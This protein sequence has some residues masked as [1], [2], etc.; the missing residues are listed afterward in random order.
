MRKYLVILLLFCMMM[1]MVSCGLSRRNDWETRPDKNNGVSEEVPPNISI[2]PND[3]SSISLKTWT[4]HS[5]DKINANSVPGNNAGKEYKVYMARGETEGFQIALRSDEDISGLSLKLV[6][7]TSG[8]SYK[9]YIFDTLYSVGDSMYPDPARNYTEGENFDLNAESTLSL[10]VEFTSVDKTSSGLYKYIFELR[11]SEDKTV[12]QYEITVKVWNILMPSKPT[13]AT[14]VGIDKDSIL[15]YYGKD[16]EKMSAET[17]LKYYNAM[18]SEGIS[19]A[20]LPYDILDE[21]ANEYMSDPRVTSFRVP[22]DVSDDTLL[23]YY[24]KIKVNPQWLRKAYFMPMTEPSTIEEINRFV[25]LA[26]RLIRL[27]PLIKV[28]APFDTDIEIEEGRD[29][30]YDM[31]YYS[32][33]WCPKLCMWDEDYSYAGHSYTHTYSFEQRMRNMM[34]SGYGVWTYMD[35]TPGQPYTSLSLTGSGLGQRASFWQQYQ[36]GINGF[37]YESST[38]WRGD[39]WESLDNGRTDGNGNTVY[40]EGILIYP[41]KNEQG[42]PTVSLRLKLMR[43]GVEDCELLRLAA[44]NIGNTKVNSIIKSITASVYETDIS[45]DEFAA[46]RIEIGNALES[47]LRK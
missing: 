18:L 19:P 35:E 1:S 13:Y 16:G 38:D 23:A 8:L 28:T 41:S 44:V 46:I 4:V 36:R 37:L 31:T 26:R 29:Q 14:S 21:R 27:C 7:G 40:G 10:L 33:L 34:M 30:I 42:E 39:P 47:Y 5:F 11:D 3:P 22:H 45:S 9:M 24:K 32:T 43:D 6:G 25:E 2:E 20:E 15:S 12:A 17:Y